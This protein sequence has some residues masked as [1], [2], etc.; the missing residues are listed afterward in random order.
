[1]HFWLAKYELSSATNTSIFASILLVTTYVQM[2][3][4]KQKNGVSV[5][6]KIDRLSDVTRLLR[7]L[8]LSWLDPRELSLLSRVSK[9]FETEAGSDILWK[10]FLA[11]T[12]VPVAPAKKKKKQLKKLLP[13]PKF[14]LKAHFDRDA[15][16]RK[17]Q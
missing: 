4:K 2:L 6:S 9:A 1:M 14:R 16:N 7:G 5:P 8:S 17:R 12:D 10:S 13:E 15:R 3:K 11:N